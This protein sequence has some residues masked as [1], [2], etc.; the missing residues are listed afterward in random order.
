MTAPLAH[1]LKFRLSAEERETLEL[2][3]AA[4]H[5]SMASVVR[6]AVLRY[7]TNRQPRDG[8]GAAPPTATEE[9]TDGNH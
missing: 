3:A 6:L 9:A 8:S 5:R 1:S 2:V 4:E 7:C